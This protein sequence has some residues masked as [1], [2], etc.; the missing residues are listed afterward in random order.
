MK[1]NKPRKRRLKLEKTYKN[2]ALYQNLKLKIYK[3][4]NWKYQIN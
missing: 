4:N 2:Q 1:L 3:T